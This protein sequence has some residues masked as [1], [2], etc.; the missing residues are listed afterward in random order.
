MY[1]NLPRIRL[2]LVLDIEGQGFPTEGYRADREDY[3]APGAV[4]GCDWS[5]TSRSSGFSK[6][7]E[8]PGV[9]RKPNFSKT[10]F[11]V[12]SRWRGRRPQSAIAHR[13]RVYQGMAPQR[14]KSAG[15]SNSTKWEAMHSFPSRTLSSGHC[16]SPRRPTEKGIRTSI[17]KRRCKDGG[18]EMV[19]ASWSYAGRGEQSGECTPR[20][21]LVKVPRP[22]TCT[23]GGRGEVSYKVAWSG[24]VDNPP[25]T[26]GEGTF[27]PDVSPVAA[28]VLEPSIAAR[29]ASGP[30]LPSSKM[31]VAVVQVPKLYLGEPSQSNG[32]N[33]DSVIQWSDSSASPRGERRTRAEDEPRVSK[34]I[35]QLRESVVRDR[36]RAYPAARAN[37]VASKPAGSSIFS[38]ASSAPD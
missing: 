31:V 10:E 25:V 14:P 15:G 22:E 26:R 32:Y 9:E 3:A 21:V 7:G 23:K 8:G 13:R 2:V 17:P 30:K 28:A 36:H 19:E 16:H 1:F 38:Y 6:P 18:R 12:Q 4:H 37:N 34:V 29:D 24:N 35:A 11:L 5:K 33:T 20:Q 27:Q